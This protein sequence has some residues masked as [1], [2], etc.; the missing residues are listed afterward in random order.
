MW[1][2]FTV[3]KSCINCDCKI[4]NYFLSL[5]FTSFLQPVPFL[6]EL[7]SCRC[8]GLN[9]WPWMWDADTRAPS[10]TLKVSQDYLEECSNFI[11][12]RP[13]MVVPWCLKRIGPGR[14]TKSPWMVKSPWIYYVTAFLYNHKPAPYYLYYRTQ[15][16]SLYSRNCDKEKSSNNL[17][18]WLA[19]S[20]YRP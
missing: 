8:W 5:G 9:P 7:L 13:C 18:L 11:L 10:Y 12:R 15:G 4:D 19:E 3:L 6:Q 14:I 1:R 2:L 17:Y 16:T 20:G